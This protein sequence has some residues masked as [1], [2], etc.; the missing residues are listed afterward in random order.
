MKILTPLCMKKYCLHPEVS[1][2]SW[3]FIKL[4]NHTHEKYKNHMIKLLHHTLP[5][6]D[7]IFK[8]I[9]AEKDHNRLMH[10]NHTFWQNKYPHITDNLCVFC[11]KE[12]ETTDHLIMCK[13]HLVQNKQN[14]LYKKLNDYIKNGF[15]WFKCA[16]TSSARRFKGFEPLV[17]SKGVIPNKLI[18]L[19]N[20]GE[21]HIHLWNT[22]AAIQATIMH[23]Q[24]S[25]W[26]KRNKI[27]FQNYNEGLT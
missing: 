4:L 7:K 17:G 16:K 25:I 10:T 19:L 13:H 20:T 11:K 24:L 23:T 26:K 22:T 15:T 5:T 18:N 9:K 14:K 21:T 12:P 6:K 1:K 8:H 27:L 2:Y 3:S